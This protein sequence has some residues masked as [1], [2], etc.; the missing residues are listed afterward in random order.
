M[1]ED[2][3]LAST[4]PQPLL[5]YLLDRASDRKLRLFLCGCLRLIPLPEGRTAWQ[6][7][8]EPCRGA[9]ETAERFA[10]GTASEEERA[11]AEMVAQD[12]EYRAEGRALETNFTL[13][14]EAY[15]EEAWSGPTAAR[16]WY[17]PPRTDPRV[18][19]WNE[20][21][22]RHLAHA[23]TRE[24]EDRFPLFEGIWPGWQFGP[25]WPHE[26]EPPAVRSL[27]LSL[28]RDLGG[29]P[30][31][32][33]TVEPYWL[34]WNHGTVPALARRIYEERAFSDLPILADALEDAGCTDAA[35]LD[36]CR[37]E[38]PHARGCWVLDLLLG[39]T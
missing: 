32:P 27:C 6:S 39:K 3:W 31:R 10:D 38:G 17:R 11:R 5:A 16:Y 34:A 25:S 30:F 14:E 20:A 9:L 7:W 1:N 35:I 19:A 15:G 24:V 26:P 13:A 4:D 29:N 23:L 21:A 33:V 2:A 37:S 18:A 28:L 36:H 22:A 12:A 8:T